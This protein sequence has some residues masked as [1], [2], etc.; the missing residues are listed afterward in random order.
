VAPGEQPN[1]PPSVELPNNLVLLLEINGRYDVADRL[2]ERLLFPTGVALPNLT[3]FRN[4]TP[5]SSTIPPRPASEARTFNDDL[6]INP[7]DLRYAE[8]QFPEIFPLLDNPALRRAFLRY[9]QRANEARLWVRRLGL[10]AVFFATVALLSAATASLRAHNSKVFAIIFEGGAVMAALV[11]GGSLWLGPWRKR[12]LESRFMTERLRQWHF[13]CLI[14]RAH[15]IEMFFENKMTPEATQKFQAQRQNWLNDF[16]HD[17]EG[18]LGSKL[19]SL[20]GD[21]DYSSDWVHDPPTKFKS[22]S[23]VLPN[24][25]DA[26]RRL[27]FRHQYDYVTHKLSLAKDL[28]FWDFLKWPLLRQ[29]SFIEGATSFCFIATILCALSVTIHHSFFARNTSADSLLGSL[30]L[31]IAIIGVA[32]RT[33]QDGLGVTKEIER[34][35]DYRSKVGRALLQFETT[36]DQH[37]RLRSMEELELAAVDE[38]RGFLRTHR[39][40]RFVL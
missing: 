4:V 23:F 25:Y 1:E 6:L 10:F 38:L 40:A 27:R 5:M 11:A 39:D 3:S 15:E 8:E 35:R 13:Q 22:D 26:Y 33:V 19:D 2:R 9:E 7:G 29:E 34:Y 16:L 24:L 12:W 18:K 14:R 17:H 36:K 32:L 20:A 30:T 21:L 31:V 37:K 28:P